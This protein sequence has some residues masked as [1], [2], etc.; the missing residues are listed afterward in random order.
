MKVS[1][2]MTKE[3]IFVSPETKITDV[4]QILSDKNLNGV[5]VVDEGKVVGM[6]TEADLITRDSMGIHIPSLIKF[7]EGFGLGKV[8][9]DINNS[10]LKSILEADA[11]LVMNDNF[12]YVNPETSLSE[13]VNKFHTHRVNPIPVVDEKMNLKGIVALSDI[14]KFFSRLNDVEID[15]LRE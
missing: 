13:L 7:I 14:V 5:P 11:R 2:I 3:V 6:I 4:T 10:N 9:E 8:K 12:I 15:F 1:D